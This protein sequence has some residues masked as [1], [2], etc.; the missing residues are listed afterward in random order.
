VYV[1]VQNWVKNGKPGIETFRVSQYLK[2][3][4]NNPMIIY[5]PC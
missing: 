3:A 2:G 4:S 5:Y 1:R